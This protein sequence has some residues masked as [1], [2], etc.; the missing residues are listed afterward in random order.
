ML[1][2]LGM[3]PTRCGA[4]DGVH[5]GVTHLKRCTPLTEKPQAG[6]R[7]RAQK[8]TEYN[9]NK[10]LTIQ[11]RKIAQH[12]CRQPRRDINY[13]MNKPYNRPKDLEASTGSG[14]HSSTSTSCS[15][16]PLTLN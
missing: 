8:P 13:N 14:V 1:V 9:N 2:S 7:S 16:T 3:V 11:H 4:H 10:A 6:I 15:D 5:H 12:A